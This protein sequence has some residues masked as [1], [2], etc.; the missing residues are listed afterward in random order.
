MTRS[1]GSSGSMR[2]YAT[3]W[4]IC[5]YN[6]VMLT[7]YSSGMNSLDHVVTDCIL[8]ASSSRLVRKRPAG[9]DFILMA[10]PKSACWLLT[11]PMAALLAWDLWSTGSGNWESSWDLGDVGAQVLSQPMHAPKVKKKNSVKDFPLVG[12]RQKPQKR[13]DPM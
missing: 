5:H 13:R 7:P 8:S 2:R 10:Q 9:R 12:S 4:G 11:L 6:C 1:L 3:L